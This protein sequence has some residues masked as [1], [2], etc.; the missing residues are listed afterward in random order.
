M[1]KIPNVEV[2]DRV[3]ELVGETNRQ[4]LLLVWLSF[5]GCIRLRGDFK[6][7]GVKLTLFFISTISDRVYAVKLRDS[8]KYFKDISDY[9]RIK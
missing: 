6:T 7:E 5:E 4:L 3:W 1:Y 9:S 2:S 8:S